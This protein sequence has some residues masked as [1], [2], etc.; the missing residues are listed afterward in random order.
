MVKATSQRPHLSQLSKEQVKILST[1]A[2]SIDKK[3]RLAL[4]RLRGA[5][6]DIRENSMA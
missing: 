3:K 4:R 1:G 2:N 5:V 6:S